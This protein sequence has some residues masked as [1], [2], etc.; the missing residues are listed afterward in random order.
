MGLRGPARM[1]LS[2]LFPGLRALARGATLDEAA[3]AAGVSRTLLWMRANEQAVCVLRDR[4]PRSGA[5]TLEE[6]EEIRVG[7]ERGES[8]SDI[9]RRLGRHR[10]TIGREIAAGGGRAGY[11]AFRGQGRADAAARRPKQPWTQERPWL[12]EQ[13]QELLRTKVWSPE[14]IAH[15]LRKD[16][17]DQPEWWV[18]HEAIYQAI[19]VQAKGE[20]RKE[21]AACLRSGRTA[22]RPHGR[23]KPGGGRIVGMVNISERPAE[24]NDRA[25]KGLDRS[26]QLAQRIVPAQGVTSIF[27]Q[28]ADVVAGR[29]YLAFRLCA[30]D[31]RPRT[32]GF[33]YFQR[34][35]DFCHQ[36][37]AQCVVLF[38]VV[39][40]DDADGSVLCE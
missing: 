8:D 10:G 40:C 1:P 11:R 28:L 21:L 27:R 24:A 2:V 18:S 35:D 5:V 19:F 16:H 14:Q 33:Q 32:R 7:I 34:F 39:Q 29:P 22:R 23:A 38:C 25:V 36:L 30:Q 6:R 31:D 17:P 13:V 4:K 20:L 9:A 26:H 3:A 37:V 12:W 15:R